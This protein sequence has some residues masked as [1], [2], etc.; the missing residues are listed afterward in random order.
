MKREIESMNF[1]R[2]TLG[3]L[4]SGVCGLVASPASAVEVSTFQGIVDALATA[5]SGAEIVV[6]PGE[7]RSTATLNVPAGVTL[8][9]SGGKGVTT[10]L[11]AENAVSQAFRSVEL[12]G[13]TSALDG[14]TFKEITYTSAA[15]GGCVVYLP[16]GGTIQNCDVV[17][18]VNHSVMG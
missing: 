2:K 5:Q 10:F 16:S 4:M 11:M 8:R 6:S 3:I 14:F 15:N 17:G 9:S 18:C 13:A 7:Y 1:R 12:G